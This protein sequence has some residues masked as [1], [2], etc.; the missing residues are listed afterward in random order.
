MGSSLLVW[1]GVLFKPELHTDNSVLWVGICKLPEQ[2][3]TSGSASP[4]TIGNLCLERDGWG[5]TVAKRVFGPGAVPYNKEATLW[6]TGD[7]NGP[8]AR[9]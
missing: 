9:R 2:P 6:G 4:K 3:V 1:T 5:E 7:P 8:R